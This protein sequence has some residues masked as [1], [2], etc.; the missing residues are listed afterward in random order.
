MQIRK[1]IGVAP[2]EKYERCA[3]KYDFGAQTVVKRKNDRVSVKWSLCG[4][5]VPLTGG[6]R[7][8]GQRCVGLRPNA[9]ASGGAAGTPL[10]P[11]PAGLAEVWQRKCGSGSWLVRQRASTRKPVT[12]L[13]PARHRRVLRGLVLCCL[14]QTS[15]THSLLAPFAVLVL[16]TQPSTRTQSIRTETQTRNCKSGSI[17]RSSRRHQKCFA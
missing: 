2:V 13:D 8:A 15:G 1:K 9:T 11:A 17:Q 4:E 7:R 10:N 6:V 16:G 5:S 14:S 3:Q 12:S